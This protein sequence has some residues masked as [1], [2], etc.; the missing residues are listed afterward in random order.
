VPAATITETA[1]S[2]SGGGGPLPPAPIGTAFRCEQTH[3]EPVA[4]LADRDLDVG[5]G[6]HAQQALADRYR[7]LGRIEP[8]FKYLLGS[9]ELADHPLELALLLVTLA[10]RRTQLAW[11]LTSFVHKRRVGLPNCDHIVPL[12]S[13]RTGTV[14]VA[15]QWA[16]AHRLYAFGVA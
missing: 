16:M 10:S 13:L 15:S 9:F 1:M 12:S 6:G 5:L 3:Q 14:L 11:P 8:D 4:V 7:L 2:G